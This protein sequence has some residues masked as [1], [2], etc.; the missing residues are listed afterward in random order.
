MNT[1]TETISPIK[2]LLEQLARV[3]KW[4]GNSGP[5]IFSLVNV[6][7]QKKMIITIN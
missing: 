4:G 1:Q 6:N 7:S 5:S 3:S 2:V